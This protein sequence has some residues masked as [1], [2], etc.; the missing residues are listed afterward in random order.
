MMHQL[1]KGSHTALLRKKERERES[2]ETCRNA[3]RQTARQV[4]PSRESGQSTHFPRKS[5]TMPPICWGAA[6]TEGAESA[7]ALPPGRGIGA[8]DKRGEDTVGG[9][10]LYVLEGISVDA[11]MRNRE[12]EM[13]RTVIY[14]STQE[15]KCGMS[16]G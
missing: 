13:D 1:Q 15:W 3:G 10:M 11:E 9:V 4:E 2:R 6:D 7:G 14:E 8:K 12:M 16:D 5:H